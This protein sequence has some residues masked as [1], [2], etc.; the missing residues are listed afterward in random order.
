MSE[1][2]PI[3]DPIYAVNYNILRIQNGMA[4]SSTQ[5]NLA[6]YIKWSRTCR[7]WNVPPRLG[8][9]KTVPTLDLEQTKEEVMFQLMSVILDAVYL[10]PVRERI[11]YSDPNVVLLM[12]DR[13]PKKLQNLVNLLRT[14]VLNHLG[15]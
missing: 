5:I 15:K 9:V 1:N 6:P 13:I 12:Y 8:S 3:N 7:R 11:D 14:M 2:T 10:S 4:A